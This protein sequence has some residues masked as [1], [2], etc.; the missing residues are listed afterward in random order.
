MRFNQP[1]H[2]NKR[3]KIPCTY[4]VYQLLGVMQSSRN[5]AVFQQPISST[6]VLGP[7]PNHQYFADKA[8]MCLFL[9]AK[10]KTNSQNLVLIHSTDNDHNNNPRFVSRAVI[11]I[12]MYQSNRFSTDLLIL[13][14]LLLIDV[15]VLPLSLYVSVRSAESSTV[16]MPVF[17]CP[18]GGGR[19]I[20]VSQV[21]HNSLSS[22]AV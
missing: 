10:W 1:C 18:Q 19:T 21:C 5:T 15:S 6:F 11:V 8:K 12:D 13:V 20:S 9:K 17:F 7:D 3:Q 16:K 2:R 4:H 22:S 14:Q